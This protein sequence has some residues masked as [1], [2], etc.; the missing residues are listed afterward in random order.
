ME[1]EMGT[2]YYYIK[3]ASKP[4]PHC[5]RFDVKEG[6][7]IGKS[8]G[9]WCFAL[10]VYPEEGISTLKDWQCLFDIENSIIR[11]EYG[12]QCPKETMVDIIA[13]RNWGNNRRHPYG[14]E[15][16]ADFYAQNNS[17]PGPNGLCRSRIDGVHC[18]GHGEGTW[19]YIIG[20]FS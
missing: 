12:D 20:D 14:Y 17:Q 7:H 11:D 6:R 5:G 3:P 13:N 9:G 1:D 15:S 10:H 19:D 16:W 18:I 4:C 2:N 8:S